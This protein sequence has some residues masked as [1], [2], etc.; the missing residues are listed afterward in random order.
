MLLALIESMK[1]LPY[2]VHMLKDDGITWIWLT[3]MH[4][5]YCMPELEVVAF[6]GERVRLLAPPKSSLDAQPLCEV[7]SGCPGRFEVCA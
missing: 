3:W 4:I 1:D 2:D 7:Y 5:K 6:F